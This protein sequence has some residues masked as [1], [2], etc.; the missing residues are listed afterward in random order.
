MVI[1]IPLRACLFPNRGN[2]HHYSTRHQRSMGSAEVFTPAK[3]T[4]HHHECGTCGMA[5]RTETTSSR[6]GELYPER[7]NGR[8]KN[9]Q[10]KH[11]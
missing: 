2:L 11:C 1:D 9:T 3:V 7:E 4:N 5:F 8:N 10:P 6:L